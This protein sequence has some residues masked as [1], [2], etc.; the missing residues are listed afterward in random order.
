MKSSKEDLQK[1]WEEV[2][3]ELGFPNLSFPRLTEKEINTASINMHTKDIIMSKSFFE[4]VSKYGS[5]K[6]AFKAISAHE[7]NHYMLCPYDLKTLM[8]LDFEATKINNSSGTDLANYFEDVIVNLDLVERG[9]PGINKIYYDFGD[10]SE[11]TETLRKVYSD[12]TG[13]YFGMRKEYL[14]NK[15]I[16]KKAKKID[17]YST[18]KDSL[19]FNIKNFV[20]LFTP[21]YDAS[22]NIDKHIDYDDYSPFEIEQA[23]KEV[24]KELSPQEFKDVQEYAK[25]KGI[26]DH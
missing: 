13:L 25:Q 4:K 24:V 20:Q 2:K 9:M 5:E 19:R 7:A 1:Y 18:D 23:F 15:E 17:Y 3:Q 8:L 16:L 26:S 22:S 21:L 6:E 14:V 10:V 12:L 11:F